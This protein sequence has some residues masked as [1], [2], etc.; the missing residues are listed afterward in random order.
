MAFH[1]GWRRA[2]KWY[3][4]PIDPY[5]IEVMSSFDGSDNP[6]YFTWRVVKEEGESI[7]TIYHFDID[8]KD[9]DDY[10]YLESLEETQDIAEEWFEKNILPRILSGELDG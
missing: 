10:S 7:K 9:C 2:V 6:M 8:K 1:E 5:K 4:I 3:F